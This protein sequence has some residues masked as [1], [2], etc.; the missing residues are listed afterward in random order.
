MLKEEEE[1]RKQAQVMFQDQALSENQ[2]GLFL[3]RKSE[4]VNESQTSAFL[5]NFKNPS[6]D[7]ITQI[8]SKLVS[9]DL[10]Q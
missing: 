8:S 1:V 2:K 9:I 10:S 3:K 7:E 4:P 5:F 6:E